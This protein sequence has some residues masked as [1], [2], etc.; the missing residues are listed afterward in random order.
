MAARLTKEIELPTQRNYRK[1]TAQQK[2][3]IVLAG[4]SVCDTLRRDGPHNSGCSAGGC[5][6][7]G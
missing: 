2:L 5:G 7:V 3:E 1:V 4:L 6:I